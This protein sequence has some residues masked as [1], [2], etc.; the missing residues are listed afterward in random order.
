[1][2]AAG[3][4]DEEEKSSGEEK[5]DGGEGEDRKIH[6]TLPSPDSTLMDNGIWDFSTEGTD[7]F[8]ASLEEADAEGSG[9][10]VFT[11]GSA[12]GDEIYT[13]DGEEEEAGFTVSYDKAEASEEDPF[14]FEEEWEALPEYEN[15]DLS[16][17]A[18]DELAAEEEEGEEDPEPLDFDALRSGRNEEA[19]P[20]EEESGT[21]RIIMA[22]LMVLVLGAVS[23]AILLKKGILHLPGKNAVPEDETAG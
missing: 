17:P 2:A 14:A 21:G 23:F 6:V 10:A 15:V 19:S 20:E 7:I 16:Y 11:L 4:E 22:F 1:M 5:E 18:G 9:K 8:G 12:S 13:Y 3:E